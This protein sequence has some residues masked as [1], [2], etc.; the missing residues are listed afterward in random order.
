[1]SVKNFCTLMGKQ[2]RIRLFKDEKI[3]AVFRS[4]DIPDQFADSRIDT[5]YPVMGDQIDLFV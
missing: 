1:M 5:I 3:V 4:N 2:I